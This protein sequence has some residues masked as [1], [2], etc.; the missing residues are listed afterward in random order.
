MVTWFD[1]DDYIVTA[2]GIGLCVAIGTGLAV[3]LGIAI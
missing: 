1:T 3:I 2:E